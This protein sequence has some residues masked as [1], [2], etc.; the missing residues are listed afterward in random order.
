MVSDSLRPHGPYSSWNS[1]GQNAG[2]GSRSLPQGIF[3]TQG[4]SPGLLHCRWILYQLSHQGR[5]IGQNRDQLFGPP[6]DGRAYWWIVL[7]SRVK[8]EKKESDSWLPVWA[9][10]NNTRIKLCRKDDDFRWT[11]LMLGC[12]L[13]F[14]TEMFNE[15]ADFHGTLTMCQIPYRT[16]YS[17]HFLAKT[18]IG[19]SLVVQWLRTFLV[20]QMVKI[21]PAMPEDWVWSLG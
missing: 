2:V 17:H 5:P 21:P 16:F 7:G 14:P 3:P 8:A 4:S 20:A 6:G 18:L 9:P 13:P 1:P 12:L 11:G 19:T 10:V 15:R